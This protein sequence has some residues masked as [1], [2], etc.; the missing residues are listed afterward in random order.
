MS[1]GGEVGVSL[2]GGVRCQVIMQLIGSA[3]S[4]LCVSFILE[5]PARARVCVLTITLHRRQVWGE[6][7]RLGPCFEGF[8]R[9]PFAARPH[10][11]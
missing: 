7:A 10:V 11:F 2:P 4:R 5:Q 8:R 1:E 9:L 6:A 3:R